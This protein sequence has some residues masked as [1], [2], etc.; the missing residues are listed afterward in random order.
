MENIIFRILKKKKFRVYFNHLTEYNFDENLECKFR[1]MF[2]KETN[3]YTITCNIGTPP[4]VL[5]RINLT[6]KGFESDILEYERFQTKLH[7]G[8]IFSI[9]KH[10]EYKATACLFLKKK[11]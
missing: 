2:T 11:N 6:F 4:K 9:K 5:Y 8:Y 3:E 1:F 10:D 7:L